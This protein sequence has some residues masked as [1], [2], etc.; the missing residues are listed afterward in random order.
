[1]ANYVNDEWVPRT[2]LVTSTA[3]LCA[4]SLVTFAG[5]V[6]ANAANSVLGVVS[7]DTKSGDVATVKVPP[8]VVEVIATGTVTA[9][10]YV[11]VLTAS[12]YVN[13]D[14]TS[15]AI[16]A[17]GVQDQADGYSVG[18]AYTGGSA[19]DTVLIAL[20]ETQAANACV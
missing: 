2:K 20:L 18:K 4:K 10:A 8:S 7:Q 17:A 19:N 11:E 13:I 9:G 16:T 15:T 3:N 14:G 5:A 1:M 6:P 12:I